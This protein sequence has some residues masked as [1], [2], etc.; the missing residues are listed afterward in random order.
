MYKVKKI[1]AAVLLLRIKIYFCNLKI[2]QY[3]KQERTRD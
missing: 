1:D 2:K 3:G